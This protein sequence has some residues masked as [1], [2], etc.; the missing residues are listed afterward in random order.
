MGESTLKTL[1]EL[2]QLD[3]NRPLLKEIESIDYD[4]ATTKKFVAKHIQSLRYSEKRKVRKERLS[5]MNAVISILYDHVLFSENGQCTPSMKRM[6]LILDPSLKPLAEDTKRLTRKKE[7]AFGNLMMAI[8]RAVCTLIDFG[9]ICVHTYRA[10]SNQDDAYFPNFFY[11][12]LPISSFCS[13]FEIYIQKETQVVFGL[14]QTFMSIREHLLRFEKIKSIVDGV[15]QAAWDFPESTFEK[16]Y[17]G[18]G[19]FAHY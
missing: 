8:Q 16:W 13:D 7:R 6:A 2:N 14:Q 4:I 10:E 3:L 18:C 17:R 19:V 11:E 15:V 12:L 9:I 1:E 5:M